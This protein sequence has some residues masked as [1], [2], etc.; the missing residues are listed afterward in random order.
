MPE[1]ARVRIS[2]IKSIKP[3]RNTTDSDILALVRWQA[4]EVARKGLATTKSDVW[5]FGVTMW[6]ILT[7]AGT[8][9][10]DSMRNALLSSWRYLPP[11]SARKQRDRLS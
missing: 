11:Y 9:Y 10:P 8:P 4:P 3:Y 7:L 1:V 6:E 5:S 2:D